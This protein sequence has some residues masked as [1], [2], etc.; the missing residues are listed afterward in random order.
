MFVFK[1]LRRKKSYFTSKFIGNEILTKM[2]L[3]LQ[4][5]EKRFPVGIGAAVRPT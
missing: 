2:Q 4:S 1:H 3:P 5:F